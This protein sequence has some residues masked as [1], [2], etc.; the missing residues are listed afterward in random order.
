M[1]FGRESGDQRVAEQL[2]L[3]YR[4]ADLMPE[5]RAL[6]D[7]AVR[8]TLRP[9]AMTEADVQRLRQLG[10]NDAAIT[11]AVQVIGYFNYINR[12]ADALH[13]DS[14][15]WMTPPREVWLA[16]KGTDYLNDGSP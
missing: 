3:D 1:D 11:I 15:D 10:F 13:V 7:Y 8:L 2:V 14:E 6:C 16:T 4:S 12:I 5:D 9:A